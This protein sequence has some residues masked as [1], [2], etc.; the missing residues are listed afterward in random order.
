MFRVNFVNSESGER[1]Y[2]LRALESP[3]QS[4]QSVRGYDTAT[5]V[6]TPRDGS[7]WRALA[8]VTPVPYTPVR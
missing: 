3:N 4:L 5:G 7:F 1:S 6:G 8:T 2:S